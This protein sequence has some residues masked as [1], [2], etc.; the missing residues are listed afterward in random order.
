[1]IRV[2]SSAIV[3]RNGHLLAVLHAGEPCWSLP[4]GGIE[5]GELSADAALREL[6][7]ECGVAGTALRLAITVENHW[8][9]G[10]RR[11]HEIDFHWLVAIPEDALPETQA[12]GAEPG[13]TRA[14][15]PLAGLGGIDLR[16][17]VLIP[18]LAHLPGTPLHLVSRG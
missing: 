16:P 12:P 1:M 13:L 18:H 15:L 3:L 9:Q 6:S 17:A 4:G 14:W 8:T 2:R 10:T 5:R 7:E 11:L